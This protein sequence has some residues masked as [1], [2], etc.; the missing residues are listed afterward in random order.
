M[1]KNYEVT[2]C[3][4]CRETLSEGGRGRGRDIHVPDEMGDDY[5]SMG[6]GQKRR[7]SQ[8]ITWW[9]ERVNFHSQ[10]EL[11]MISIV[12]KSFVFFCKF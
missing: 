10:V 6:D 8:E 4:P 3:V 7:L 1:S 9:R 11:A 5:V 12:F 2:A